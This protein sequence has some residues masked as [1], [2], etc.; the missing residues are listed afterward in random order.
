M[1]TFGSERGEMVL[2]PM[3]LGE[4]KLRSEFPSI[5]GSRLL[6]LREGVDVEPQFWVLK[7]EI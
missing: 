4:E 1:S 2:A 3:S 6:D 5:W 7:V